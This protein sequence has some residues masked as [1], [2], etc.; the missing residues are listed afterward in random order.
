LVIL[1]A[2][3]ATGCDKPAADL[4]EWT[5]A[6]HNN[7]GDTRLTARRQRQPG[8]AARGSNH[9]PPSQRNPLID[10]A[11][12]K[13]CANCHGKLGRGNGPQSA[14]FKV[15]DLTDPAWQA[16][17]KDDAMIDIIRKGKDKMPA[18]N[19]PDATI[20]ELVQHIRD[21][22]ERAAKRRA[23]GLSARDDD[24]QEL[25]EEAEAAAAE[26]TSAASAHGAPT[27]P[28]AG[29]NVPASQAEAAKAVPPSTPGG[30]PAA[31][32]ASGQAPTSGSAP[33]GDPK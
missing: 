10:V 32:P 12:Q 5:V 24:E 7:Q 14:M 21:L 30:A 4:A 8:A 19:L 15:R 11:W 1:A 28:A 6:D 25:Q 31:Q 16:A 3:S 29:A 26:R 23:R 17:A 9:V 22:G 27:A 33:A 2:W 20:K 18:F 13:Q